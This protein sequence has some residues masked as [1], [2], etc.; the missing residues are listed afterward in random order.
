MREAAPCAAMNWYVSNM[1]RPH[2]SFRFV[3]TLRNSE[4]GVND[5]AKKT[6]DLHEFLIDEMRDLYDAEKQLTKALP[7]MAKAAGNEELRNAITEHLEVTKGQ[8]ARLEE[9]FEHLEEKPRSKPCK[10]MKG[11]LDEGREMLEE[12]MEEPVMDAAIA[13]GGRKIE[14]YEIVSYE[15]LHAIA[16]QLGLEEVA[17]LLN[18]TLEEEREA[19]QTLLQIC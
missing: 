8:V 1:R 2:N 4:R 3:I 19:D 10:G 5:M 12:D 18:Q 17:E 14:H 9:C 7:R 11:I 6:Q 13:A 16:E 15:S